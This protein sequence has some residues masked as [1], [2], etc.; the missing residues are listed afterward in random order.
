VQ[1]RK[2]GRTGLNVSALGMGTMRLPQN[3][4]GQ[5]YTGIPSGNTDT[6]ASISMLRRAVDL[7]IN[8]VD[9]A[10]NYLSGDSETITGLALK[11]GYRNKV[12]LATKAP[13]WMYKAPDDF[14]LY[15][16]KQ[17]ERLQTDYIDVYLLHGM[18]KGSWPK[19]VLR[20]DILYKAEQARAAGK[21]R[22]LGFSFHDDLD[23]FRTIINAH[24]RWDICLIQLNYM[25]TQYQAGIKGLEYA[26][27][28]GIGTAIMEP[29]RGGYLANRLPNDARQIFTAAHPERSSAEW[30][31]RY[32][33]D[34]P[35]VGVVLSG[36]V[37]VGEVEENVAYAD[38][39]FSNMLTEEDKEVYMAVL[40]KLA[41]YP[42]VPCTGCAYCMHCPKRIA[43]PHNFLAYNEYQ[44]N[45]DLEKARHY[46]GTTLLP[47]GT[48]AENCITCRKCE[49][50][51][52]QH[53]PISEWMPKIAELLGNG[54]KSQGRGNSTSK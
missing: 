24:D 43:I 14:D 27:A 28:R 7:G 6:D 9:T 38:S 13:T 47:F 32:L 44:T 2:L 25:D 3:D 4:G 31:F 54:M 51:C 50:V 26:A 23:L 18:N 1:Y 19:T 45:G 52:P 30:A 15:L 10:F 39:A 21:I 36:M 35:D 16:N 11:D 33:W 48:Q 40:D 5:G 8:Y 29:L 41:S 53:I 37:S 42:V 20:Y 12:I 17:L 22:F 46:Y 34:L 49:E